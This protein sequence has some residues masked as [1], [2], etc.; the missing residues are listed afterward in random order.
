MT[1]KYE[2]LGASAPILGK[3][4]TFGAAASLMATLVV[5]SVGLLFSAPGAAAAALRSAL[6]S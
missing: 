5:T 6:I 2:G 3:R 1:C 4:V